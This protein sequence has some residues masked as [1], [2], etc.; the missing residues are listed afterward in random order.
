MASTLPSWKW[1]QPVGEPNVDDF[2]Q[3]D[4]A[5]L[6]IS[7]RAYQFLSKFSLKAAE[8]REA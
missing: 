7:E 8:I 6:Y 1:L 3:D 5:S 4:M 2:W